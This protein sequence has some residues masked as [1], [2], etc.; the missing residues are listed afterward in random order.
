MY[1]QSL[2]LWHLLGAKTRSIFPIIR[3]R[4][5][6]GLD[7]CHAFHFRVPFGYSLLSLSSLSP[8]ISAGQS[9][10]TL[11][12]KR[13]SGSLEKPGFLLVSQLSIVF[14]NNRYKASKRWENIQVYAEGFIVMIFEKVAQA[15]EFLVLKETR[16]GGSLI[17]CFFF[18]FQICKHNDALQHFTSSEACTICW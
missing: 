16:G 11:H 2:K 9:Q 4:K 3:F 12:G 18:F 7:H 13:N 6:L 17:K 15:K 5:G 1:G 10:V 14:Q 8:P